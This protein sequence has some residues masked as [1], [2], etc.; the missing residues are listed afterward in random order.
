MKTKIFTRENTRLF[1][2]Y[3]IEGGSYLFAVLTLFFIF[4]F[5][6]KESSPNELIFAI[7][8]AIFFVILRAVRISYYG[9][10]KKKNTSSYKFFFSGLKV[11]IVIVLLLGIWG[12]YQIF[13]TSG[14]GS[15]AVYQ[16]IG[17]GI[18]V[19]WACV[20]LSYF[21][22]AVY[23]YNIN[24]GLT[25]DE[26]DKIYK[27]KDRKAKG[28]SYSVDD[29]KIEPEYNPYQNETFGLPG[30][31]VRGMIAFTLLFG[32]ISMLIVSIGMENQFDNNA[33]FWDQY[34]FFK[35]AFL[36]MIAFYFGSRSL[37]YLQSRNESVVSG[38]KTNEHQN[39][40]IQ[41]QIPNLSTEQHTI[42]LPQFDS[43]K[44]AGSIKPKP[45][46]KEPKPGE[47]VFDPMKPKA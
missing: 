9:K 21:I 6:N 24:L 17:L 41:V 4:L 44:D 43:M 15:C 11:I 12:V 14:C 7:I 45:A 31:T 22:W 32:A 46:K 25:E 35:T 10:P 5:F 47:S 23:Y 28:E 19:I 16:A 3:I 36:M 37:Q 42:K 33:M 18:I 29:L 13:T 26:W 20:F 27:A 40:D 8:S 39:N 2:K 38:N 34:E 1:T 30:G